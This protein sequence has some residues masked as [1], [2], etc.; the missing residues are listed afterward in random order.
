MA[1]VRPKGFKARV[2]Y[3]KSDYRARG[4][5]RKDLRMEL[6]AIRARYFVPGGRGFRAGAPVNI[7]AKYRALKELLAEHDHSK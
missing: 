1:I 7:R 4:Y 6:N 3:W 5:G 2:T